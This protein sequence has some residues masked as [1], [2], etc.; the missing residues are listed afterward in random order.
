MAAVAFRRPSLRQDFEFAHG[1]SLGCGFL[2]PLPALVAFTV[3]RLCYCRR[4]SYFA[5]QEN[6]DVE[7]AAFIRD[8]QSVADANFACGLGKLPVRIRFCQARRPSFAKGRVLKNREAQSQMSI[9]TPV[10]RFIFLQSRLRSSV[11]NV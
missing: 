10:M 3:E 2:S 7:V 11:Q 6:F 9:R 8:A 1:L 5:E 4:T